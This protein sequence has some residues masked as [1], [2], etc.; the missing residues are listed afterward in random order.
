MIKIY[1][2]GPLFTEA[3]VTQRKSE[4][5][6]LRILLDNLNI[7]YSIFNPID[8]PLSDS[9]TSV[10]IFNADY[11]AIDSSNVFFFDLANMDTGT[12]V[13]LGI[14]VEKLQSNPELK[15]YPVISDFR[16]HSKLVGLDSPIGFNSFVMG[17]LNVHNIKV[18][19]SFKE[20]LE[21]FKLDISK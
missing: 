11:N 1:N 13:E 10:T 4:G 20:A 16:V 9:P 19:Y 6:Q 12:L 18:F 14:V 8:L 3:E 15:I 2:A 7:D 21:Q 5:V 17:A